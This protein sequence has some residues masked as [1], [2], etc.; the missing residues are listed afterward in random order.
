MI[1]TLLQRYAYI[2]RSFDWQSIT[3]HDLEN[4]SRYEKDSLLYQAREV[5]RICRL[6]FINALCKEDLTFYGKAIKELGSL[7]L[8]IENM[9]VKETEIKYYR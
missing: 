4:F 9:R 1:L 7:I 3:N 5:L 6:S 2:N 8:N